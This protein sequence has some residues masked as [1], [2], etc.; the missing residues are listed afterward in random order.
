MSCSP[1]RAEATC[2]HHDATL[3]TSCGLPLRI[4]ARCKIYPP[5]PVPKP[6]HSTSALWGCPTPQQWPFVTAPL[7]TSQQPQDTG[8]VTKAGQGAQSR[9]PMV[10][11]VGL[12]RRYSSPTTAPLLRCGT[13]P[14]GQGAAG[15]WGGVPKTDFVPLAGRD[16]IEGGHSRAGHLCC[17]HQPG[18]P[19]RAAGQQPGGCRVPGVPGHQHRVL[20]LVPALLLPAVPVGLE[21]GPGRVPAVPAAHAPPLPPARGPVPRSAGAGLREEA[22]MAWPL[23]A[24]AA[25]LLRTLGEEAKEIHE[26]APRWPPG[27]SA[28]PRQRLPEEEAVAAAEE[29]GRTRRGTDSEV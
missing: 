29:R 4:P 18:W 28:R 24:A 16:V 3:G 5:T 11:S 19:G 2:G 14:E 26:V 17:Q 27:V 23:G 25:Q 6:K 9:N 15:F 8:H 7:V 10:R 12:K 13:A 21:P 1:G 22:E 20:Q